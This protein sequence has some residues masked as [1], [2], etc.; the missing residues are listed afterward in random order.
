MNG[1]KEA[2]KVI[3]VRTDHTMGNLIGTCHLISLF[4]IHQFD[5]WL[6]LKII[7]TIYFI[8]LCKDEEDLIFFAVHSSAQD[9]SLSLSS[10]RCRSFTTLSKFCPLLATYIPTLS[11]TQYDWRKIEQVTMKTNF[12]HF[13][14]V[15]TRCCL[16]CSTWKEPKIA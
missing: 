8:P 2:N 12:I 5:N 3:C 4:G 11:E 13:W 1:L 16:Y 14:C 7:R 6:Q 10:K 9:L 15:A